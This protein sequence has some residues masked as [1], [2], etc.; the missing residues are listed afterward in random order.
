[1]ILNGKMQV[2]GVYNMGK[3]NAVKNL[4]FEIMTFNYIKMY[5]DLLFTS[6]GSC[7]N[8]K[9]IFIPY[10]ILMI[11]GFY[12]LYNFTVGSVILASLIFIFS[13]VLLIWVNVKYYNVKNMY[14][15]ITNSGMLEKIKNIIGIEKFNKINDS[16]IS[17]VKILKIMNEKGAESLPS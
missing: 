2:R 13:P 16:E 3:T 4:Y 1:M 17:L 9:S 8:K 11:L 7:L 5:M 6:K 10:A 12:L 14:M 15:V